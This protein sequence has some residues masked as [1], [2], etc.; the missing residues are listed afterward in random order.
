LSDGIK[1]RALDQTLSVSDTDVLIVDK[2][3]FGDNSLTFHIDY[4]DFRKSV[5]TGDATLEG[6][7]TVKGDTR[8]EG[9]T[10]VD[11]YDLVVSN[12]TITTD[13]YVS[14]GT[15]LKLDQLSDVDVSGAQ[16]QDYLMY[17]GNNWV[18]A[19]GSG[20]GGGGGG[21]TQTDDYIILEGGADEIVFTVTVGAKSTNNQFYGIGSNNCFYIDG[22]EAPILM[23][24][25]NRRFVFDQSHPSNYGLRMMFS[26]EQS[27]GV[28]GAS[29]SPGTSY[30]GTPGVSGA[31]SIIEF[32]TVMD[33]FLLIESQTPDKLYYRTENAN[34]AQKYMG[35][36]IH[37]LGSSIKPD[38]LDDGGSLFPYSM[39]LMEALQDLNTRLETIESSS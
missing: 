3:S 30:E 18:P 8:L 32:T 16:N 19:A 25:P 17:D 37:N 12:T 11:G 2:D 26:E 4:K 28:L 36:V 15:N 27:E 31:K 34:A 14:G 22:K 39:N 35:A 6:D 7:F 29:S 5:F 33:G 21:G 23:I 9:P 20:G 13:L 10:I 1:I 24:P 38:V